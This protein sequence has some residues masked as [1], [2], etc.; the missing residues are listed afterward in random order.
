MVWTI[1]ETNALINKRRQTNQARNNYWNNLA[2]CVNR[3][4]NSNYTGDQCRRKFN[5]LVSEY[6]DM[7]L[8]AANDRRGARRHAGR[9]Y[10]AD[11]HTRFWE[12]PDKN[13]VAITQR[14]RDVYAQVKLTRGRG[15]DGGVGGEGGD[16][17]GSGGGDDRDGD[18]EG[19]GG[20]DRNGDGGN[21]SV[22]HE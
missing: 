22:G 12:K 10:F 20:G 16:S 3:T 19:G 11:F 5:R 14:R 17:G 18:S 9:I 4:C 2:A 7:E 1:A 6:N 13:A 15:R 21:E 8:Y